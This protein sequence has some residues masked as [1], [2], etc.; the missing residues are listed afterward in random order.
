MMLMAACDAA[1]HFSRSP[2]DVRS[3]NLEFQSENIGDEYIQS[4]PLRQIYLL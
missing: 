4:P 3:L 1:V 2:R